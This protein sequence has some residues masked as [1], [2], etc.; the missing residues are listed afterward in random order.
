M[1]DGDAQ[2]TTQQLAAPPPVSPV[3]STLPQQPGAAPQ[4][5][6]ND[7]FQAWQRQQQNTAGTTQMGPTVQ[8]PKQPHNPVQFRSNNLVGDLLVMGINAAGKA[9]MGRKQRE[10]ESV[11]TDYQENVKGLQE[12]QGQKQQATEMIRDAVERLK[13]NPNDNE[14]RQ[15]AYQGKTML[16]NANK[17]VESNRTNLQDMFA[18]PKGEKHYKMIAKG[19]GLDEKTANSPDRQ[20]AIAAYKKTF[21]VDDKTANLASRAPQRMQLSPQAQQQQVARQAGVVGAPATAGQ[22][23][24]AQTDREKMDNQ[25]QTT[26]ENRKA[27]FLQ[28]LP[29]MEAQGL[30]FAKDK[31]GKVQFDA[32]GFPQPQ[33]MTAAEIKANPVQGARQEQLTAVMEWQKAR[34][35]AMSDPNSPQNKAR[36]MNAEANMKRANTM[37]KLV[38]DGDIAGLARMVSTKDMDLSQVPAKLK[39]TVANL[40]KQ[41]NPKLNFEDASTEFAT[42]KATERDF[43]VGQAAKNIRSLNTGI[44]HLQQLSE[45]ADALNNGDVAALNRLSSQLKRAGFSTEEGTDAVTVFNTIEA[46]VVGE[47]ASTYKGT[48]ATDQEITDIKKSFSDAQAKHQ[49]KSAVDTTIHL[50]GSRL[51]ALDSQY[52]M[53]TGQEKFDVLNPESKAILEQ[54]GFKTGGAAGPASDEELLELL[55][56]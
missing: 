25:K 28:S 9:I 55:N 35:E 3:A 56:K 11:H 39:G 44:G 4:Q 19:L 20:A 47:V 52:K 12:A 26:V 53:G 15:Q 8:Q 49:T 33:V 40:A 23:L 34:A 31:D 29:K 46:A 42:K 51:N 27:T 2:P 36:M 43:A 10:V 7:M 54:R 24:K 30:E 6:M 13:A 41:L 1:A 45:A 17:A 38:S 22:I 48:G 21:G 18:G 16:E 37:A 5:S 32:Q 14:A 50:F